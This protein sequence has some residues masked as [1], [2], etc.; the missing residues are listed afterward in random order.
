M[1]SSYFSPLSFFSSLFE[2]SGFFGSHEE[3]ST[4]IN[5]NCNAQKTGL[6]DFDLEFYS[7][8]SLIEKNAHFSKLFLMN[9]FIHCS[10]LIKSKK[11]KQNHERFSYHIFPQ[12]K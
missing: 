9:P 2:R 5:C 12:S 1:K 10:R 8:L 3:I 7:V 6:V 11:H 4:H